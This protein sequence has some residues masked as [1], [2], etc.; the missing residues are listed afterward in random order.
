MERTK[1][2]KSENRGKYRENQENE[3]DRKGG[4]DREMEKNNNEKRE[5]RDNVKLSCFVCL[6]LHA[7]L[8]E[9]GSRNRRREKSLTEMKD[10]VEGR[11]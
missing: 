4:R 3:E 5:S 2:K 11:K 10:L 6:F 8:N 9:S 7:S 1:K